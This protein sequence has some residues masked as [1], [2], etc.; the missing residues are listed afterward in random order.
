MSSLECGHC[1]P[2]LPLLQVLTMVLD[3]DPAIVLTARLEATD[4]AAHALPVEPHTC[5]PRDQVPQ[6]LLTHVQQTTHHL[7]AV[8]Q[9]HHEAL[10][11]ARQAGASWRQLAAATGLSPSGIRQLLARIPN[12]ASPTSPVVQYP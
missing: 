5:G 8:Q 9:A 11:A 3:I 1:F 4:A 10:V 12:T 2:S 7:A 6:A